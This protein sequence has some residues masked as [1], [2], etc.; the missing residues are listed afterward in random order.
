M[1][2][3]I[4]LSFILF[5]LTSMYAADMACCGASKKTSGDVLNGIQ[6]KIE[7]AMNRCFMLNSVSP[8]DSLSG[9]LHGLEG[10]DNLVQ[11]W[12]A[13][14]DYYKSVFYMKLGN[15]A[16]SEKVIKEASAA[17][18]SS[19]D[20]TSE[21]YALLAL[22]QSFSIQFASGMEAG[23]ISSDI[24]RNAEKAVELDSANVRGWYV[25]GSNDYYTPA[26]FGGGS[27][28]EYYLKKAISPAS[29]NDEA[30]CLPTWG[31]EYAYG[32]LIRYYIQNG[33]TEEAKECLSAAEKEYPDSYFLSGYKEKL[34]L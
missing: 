7:S 23:K 19:T 10:R 28:V 29:K 25:L 21:D 30:S 17:L 9:S 4:T 14:V 24:R 11:Y 33:K 16:E 31:S 18:N 20:K 27:K 5:V 8:L 13:Y 32:L 34:G 15:R 6:G 26:S 22:I 2:K 3:I 1:K 12:K